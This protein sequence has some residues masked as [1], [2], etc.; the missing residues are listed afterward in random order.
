MV[1][2][3]GA[4]LDATDFV[5]PDPLAGHGNG[6]NTITATSW[7]VL[8]SFPVTLTLSNPHP[9]LNMLV[10][11]RYGAWLSASAN[12][13]RIGIDITGS[14][15]LSPGVGAGGASGW[16]EIPATGTSTLTQSSGSFT[17]KLPPSATAA[18]FRVHAYRDSA[19]GTQLVRFPTLRLIPLRYTT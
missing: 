15:T 19:T 5:L 16:G 14:V 4:R 18:T 8:P 17:I 12:A 11:V 7:T 13:V 9:T 10:D 3:A 1:I 2:L 6:D